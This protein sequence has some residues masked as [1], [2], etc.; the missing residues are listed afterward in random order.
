MQF[1]E[2]EHVELQ[3]EF[4]ADLLCREIVCMHAGTS[5]QPAAKDLEKQRTSF[6]QSLRRSSKTPQPTPSPAATPTSPLTPSAPSPLAQ[7]SLQPS[8]LAQ[9]PP[10][11][12]KQSAAPVQNSTASAD[13]ARQTEAADTSQSVQST[14]DRTQSTPSTSAAQQQ[15]NGTVPDKLDANGLT[16]QQRQLSQS[17]ISSAK[18]SEVTNGHRM[19]QTWDANDPQMKVSAEEEAFL[20][21]LGWTEPGDDEDGKLQDNKENTNQTFYREE[22]WVPSDFPTASC[23][24]TYCIRPQNGLRTYREGWLYLSLR[25]AKCL[26]SVLILLPH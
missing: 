2:G 18:E 19:G 21:S 16:Q 5:K 3:S 9:D 10:G 12:S 25:S 22:V 6:F 11:S 15:Q 7:Q 1:E 14:S 17:G 8:S 26:Q 13:T 24:H 23:K 4:A 20:R